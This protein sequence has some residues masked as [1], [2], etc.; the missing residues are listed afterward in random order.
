MEDTYPDGAIMQLHN[1]LAQRQSQPRP[2]SLLQGL[3]ADL[4]EV[5]EELGLVGRGDT[6]SRV[7]D[8]DGDV[9]GDWS[10]SRQARKKVTVSFVL[11]CVVVRSI[12]IYRLVYYHS[13]DIDDDL[14]VFWTELDR[15]A[16][17]IA[18]DMLHTKTVT[19]QQTR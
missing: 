3:G 11:C 1:G 8:R 13:I 5:V 7:R 19:K 9:H 17:E 15:I 14:L 4:H 2:L 6:G 12:S 16:E 10:F 18:N